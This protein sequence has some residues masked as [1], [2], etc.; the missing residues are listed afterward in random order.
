MDRL[1]IHG[2]NRLTGHISVS[3]SKNAVLP[4]LAACILLD[5]PVTLH[6]VPVLMDVRVMIRMLN[7][8][9]LRAD[10]CDTNS[11]TVFPARCLK[12]MAPYDL[13]TAMRA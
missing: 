12:T 9:G 10:Y 5:E 7:A 2:G 6:N 3:G 13:V 11:V 4:I 1:I 8:L